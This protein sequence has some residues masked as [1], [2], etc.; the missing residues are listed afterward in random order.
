MGTLLFTDVF[1]IDSVSDEF[2]KAFYFVSNLALGGN[3]TDVIPNPSS[4]SQISLP[5]L[6]CLL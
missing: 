4:G 5:F 2:L 1:N 3:F 6:K